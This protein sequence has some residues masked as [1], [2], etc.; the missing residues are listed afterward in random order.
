MKKFFLITLFFLTYSFSSFADNSY[1]MDVTKVLNTSKPG[2]QAQKKLQ[3]KIE[4]ENNKFKKLE[5]DIRK[6][7][8]EIISQK[9]ALSTE[10]YQKKISLLRKKVGDLQKNK[11]TS[12]NNIGK[13]RNKARQA[14]LKAINPIVKKYMTDNNIRVILDKNSIVMGDDSLEI[15]NKIIEILNKELP[16][17]KID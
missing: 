8:S 17:L 3:A 13:S 11:Q 1:F 14:L 16:S 9:K 4:S 5:Q 10:E 15:T 2:A 7:E 6:E 12:F